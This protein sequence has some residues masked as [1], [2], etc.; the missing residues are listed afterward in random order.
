MNPI[1]AAITGILEPL[2]R[3]IP[4]PN[5]RARMATD[6][7]NRLLDAY[8][9]QDQAQA[10]VNKVEAASGNVFV[11]GW[12]PAI[13]WTCAAAVAWAFVVGPVAKW[14]LVTLGRSVAELPPTAVDENLWALM[15]AMLGLGGLRTFEKVRGVTR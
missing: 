14:V 12:R 10:E 6:A 7:T 1:A 4:D 13:G 3:F 8:S 11:A 9:A 2:L 15:F 5:E